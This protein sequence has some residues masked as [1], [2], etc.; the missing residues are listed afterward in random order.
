MKPEYIL[1]EHLS[2]IFRDER[3]ETIQDWHNETRN[4][5][6]NEGAQDRKRCGS[7]YSRFLPVQMGDEN[8]SQPSQV[9]QTEED[10]RG[11]V[12][13]QRGGLSRIQR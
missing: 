7:F 10:I 5:G 8:R 3:T 9:V 2:D 13:T 6:P 11:V 1:H 12:R 4:R